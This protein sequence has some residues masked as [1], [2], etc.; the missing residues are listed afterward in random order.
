MKNG[1][2]I[3]E[4]GDKHWYLDDK[5]HREDG[6][7]QEWFNG[8]KCWYINDKLHR[9]DGPAVELANGNYRWFLNGKLHKEDG[10]AVSWINET[11][12]WWLY[13]DELGSNAVGFWAHWN[14]L[15]HQQRCN[16]NLHTWL[17]KYST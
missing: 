1:L 10:P 14:L 12:D 13:G 11:V 2:H 16:L 4:N 9:E 15:S 5:L 8:N 17:A 6:P 7:A 3:D